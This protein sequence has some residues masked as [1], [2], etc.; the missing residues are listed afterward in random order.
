[1]ISASFEVIQVI[2]KFSSSS[3]IERASIDE[4]YIDI[5]ASVE[6]KLR[7]VRAESSLDWNTKDSHV[8]EGAILNPSLESDLR[9]IL[10]SQICKEIRD[11]VKSETEFDMSAGIAHNK[12]MAKLASSLNKPAKQTIVPSA[13]VPSMVA[14]NIFTSPLLSSPPEN[15]LVLTALFFLILDA[16]LALHCD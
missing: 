14:S 5:T 15:L 10:G 13:S 2:Q 6:E 12:Q 4:V 11:A 7:E 16:K 3:C 8:A 1:M 9:L